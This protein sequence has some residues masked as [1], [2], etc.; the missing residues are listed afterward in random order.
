MFSHIVNPVPGPSGISAPRSDNKNGVVNNRKEFYAVLDKHLLDLPGGNAHID[1]T[2]LIDPSLPEDKKEELID[3][4]IRSLNTQERTEFTAV[5]PPNIREEL[6]VKE[7]QR[8]N[9]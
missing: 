3:E 6:L 1:K 5:L 7:K 4:Q 2:R 8:A 9:H